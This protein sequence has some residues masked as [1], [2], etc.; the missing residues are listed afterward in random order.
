M[1]GAEPLALKEVQIQWATIHGRSESTVA[2]STIMIDR[3]PQEES[4]A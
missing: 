2:S 4:F 3:R 1:T